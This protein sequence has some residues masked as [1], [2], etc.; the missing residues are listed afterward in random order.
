M[1]EGRGIEEDVVPAAKGGG[2]GES[3]EERLERLKA[4]FHYEPFW[5]TFRRAWEY[6]ERRRP[7]IYEPEDFFQT[8]AE[9]LWL[10]LAGIVNALEK[11]KRNEKP[12]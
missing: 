1:G 2:A 4:A 8:L 12:E 6:W 9:R 5:V 11:R 7:W 10:E 3:G